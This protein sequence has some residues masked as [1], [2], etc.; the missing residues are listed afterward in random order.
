[1]FKLKDLISNVMD[2]RN[3]EWNDPLFIGK[4][5]LNLTNG[6][7]AAD[8]MSGIGNAVGGKALRGAL[9]RL[10]AVRKSDNYKSMRIA[11]SLA[12]LLFPFKIIK[13]KVMIPLIGFFLQK[14]HEVVSTITKGRFGDVAEQLKAFPAK[15]HVPKA[16]QL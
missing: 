15:E 2:R 7:L 12:K 4:S 9:K 1:M 10:L 16:F 11:G 8:W 6:A 3:Q 5:I 13:E 14:G